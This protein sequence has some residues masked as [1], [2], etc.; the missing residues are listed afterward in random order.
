MSN[1]KYVNYYVEILTN[2]LTDAVIRNVS[3]QANAK[4]SEDI[5]NEQLESVNQSKNLNDG[6]EEKISSLESQIAILN[7]QI[8]ELNVCKNEYESIKGQI[9]HVDTFRAE[10]VKCRE[11]YDAQ[12]NEHQNIINELNNNHNNTVNELN[13]NHNNIVNELKEKIEYLQLTPAKRKK[14]D[15][16]KAL[17]LE[18]EKS[19]PKANIVKQ[20]LP[21]MIVKDG[22]NF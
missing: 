9:Q 20:N 11:S 14:V 16:A 17:Q 18:E 1:E 21:G 12:K 3:L 2:T 22:G 7:Q 8:A 6:K 4:I 10:L 5:I 15:E 19:Q 13:N